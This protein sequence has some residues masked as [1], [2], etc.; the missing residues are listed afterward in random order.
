MAVPERGQRR[1]PR[2]PDSV[3]P[4]PRPAL[5]TRHRPST[6]R[7]VLGLRH[8]P[9]P[10]P[11]R[12]AVLPRH[13]SAALLAIGARATQSTRHRGAAYKTD[14]PHAKYVCCREVTFSSRAPWTHV[15]PLIGIPRPQPEPATGAVEHP[16]SRQPRSR[17]SDS[18]ATASRLGPSNRMHWTVTSRPQPL[19]SVCR[20]RVGRRAETTAT[21]GSFRGDTMSNTPTV[22]LVHGAFA[23][24]SSFAPHRPR[25]ARRRHPCARRRR[26]PT[27]AWPATPPTSPPSSRQIDGPVLLVGHSYG[28]A[29]IT[30][31]G[32]EDNVVGLV[33]L[34][35]YALDEGESLGEL[36]APLP[37]LRRWPRR[38]S[39]R[40]FPVE[41]S[42]E[43][44]SRRV[45]G[46]RPVP[47]DLRRRRRPRAH[48]RA[49]RLPAAARRRRLRRAGQRCRLEDQALPGASS[50]PPTAP[51]TRTSSGSATSAPR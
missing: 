13:A 27:A 19:P 48:P 2:R 33:Y 12:P 42:D 21:G 41:G 15:A 8:Q 14:L 36:Q 51:S 26:Y 3:G 10:L 43:P 49:R 29:V 47:R 28:G 25:A 4:R 9:D 5:A 16:R 6:P 7:P 35:G 18:P 46:R 31:A 24:A 40:P 30:V 39:T 20:Q 23:D 34:A 50:P 17:A 32:V 22:V 38:W 37:R 44:G 11:R 1:D 45:G